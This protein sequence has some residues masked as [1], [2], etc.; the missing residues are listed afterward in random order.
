MA[1]SKEPESSHIRI[2]RA[3]TTVATL[4]DVS[5]ATNVPFIKVVVGLS[6]LI[7]ETVQ[8]VQTNK[9]ECLALIEQIE[10]LIRIV[11]DL[12][13][14]HSQNLPPTILSTIGTFA[15]TLQKI[16]S[17]M[18]SQQSMGRIKRFFKQHENSS[19]L[20]DCKTGLQT[21]LHIFQAQIMLNN[22]RQLAAIRANAEHTQQELLAGIIAR[23]QVD[24]DIA[25]LDDSTAYTAQSLR[26]SLSAESFFLPGNPQIFY[27]RER[28][29]ESIVKT[30]LQESPRITIL[31][32]GGIG[33]TSIALAALHHATIVAKFAQRYFVSCEAAT[34]PGSLMAAV[35]SGLGLELSGKLSQ[36]IVK[37]LVKTGGCILVLDNFETPWERSETQEQVDEFLSLL[38]DIPHLA[39]IL[40]MR[41][42]ERPLKV[43]WTRPFLPPLRPLAS[44]AARETFVN[45]AGEDPEDDFC[46]AELLALTGN[47]PLAVNLMARLASFEGCM[48]LLSR[49]RSAKVSVLSDGYSKETDLQ[50]SLR[51]SLSSPRVLSSPG[52]LQLLSLLSLLPDGVLESDLV[53]SSCPIPDLMRCKTT[54]LRTALAY[55]DTDHRLKVLVPVREYIVSTDPPSIPLVRSLRQYWDQ[56]LALRTTYQLPSGDLIPRI[57]D[58]VG[59]I[60][61]VLQYSVDVGDPD[62][63]DI[64]YNIFHL[65]EFTLSTSGSFTPLMTNI[66]DLVERVDDNQL[67]G[68]HLDFRFNYGDIKADQTDASSLAAQCAH[69]FQLAHDLKGE[70]RCHSRIGFYYSRAGDVQTALKHFDLAVALSRQ[71][72]DNATKAHVLTDAAAL[73]N[74]AGK[75][76]AALR[77]AQEAVAFAALVGNYPPAAS[78]IRVEAR[79]WVSLGNFSRG[80]ELC[81]QAQQL[82]V[83]AGFTGGLLDLMLLDFKSD[84]HIEMTEYKEAKHIH[85]GIVRCTSL[86]KHVFLHI[87][88]LAYITSLDITFGTAGSAEDVLAAINNFRS[89]FTANGYIRAIPLLDRMLADFFVLQGRKAEARTLYE[90]CLVAAWD[91]QSAA[92]IADALKQLGDITLQLCDTESTVHTA[93]TYLAFAKA[94]SNPRLVCWA[95]RL[96][97]DIFLLE[98]EEATA[99][100]LFQI[101]LDDFTRMSIHQGR[102]ECLLRMANLAK[103]QGDDTVVVDYRS[104]AKG[105]FLNLGLTVEAGKIDV[106]V[107][108][109]PRI[110]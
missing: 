81:N 77:L 100:A 16:E 96:L 84:I 95:F 108:I 37:F 2:R 60:T 48:R 101:A 23:D 43:R 28:E 50:T 94:K 67:R 33:K 17:F 30:L 74:T 92:L 55:I 14:Q 53:N 78:A 18:Q 51:L 99:T 93:Y 58:N 20:E 4:R 109:P 6:T 12:C 70:A 40:T 75:H 1:D 26:S 19:Q 44:E 98:N 45:I 88:S 21:A 73:H 52:A 87:N 86:D 9:E 11:I 76:R 31:G 64:V 7:L 65:N 8:T 56:L 22:T 63:K 34:T 103:Q 25:S 97:G 46:I 72:D 35:A 36:A 27:G 106:Q 42:Q 104:K 62:L 91:Y 38:A 71:C 32:P 41:G 102:A 3:G 57:A 110:S 61:S 105:I 66:T 89:L 80:I 13:A 49:Y 59:N 85:E 54:L 10:N 69:Y 82:V 83:A 68:F 24:P 90:K 47:L 15:Q 29:L 5:Q 79:A 107:D 39:L